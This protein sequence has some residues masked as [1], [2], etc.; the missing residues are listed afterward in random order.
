MRPISRAK[1]LLL[2]PRSEWRR[3]DAERRTPAQLL[4]SPL[5]WMAAIPAVAGF[6]GLSYVGLPVEGAAATTRLRLPLPAGLV[7]LALSYLLALGG[8]GLVGLIAHL[9][10]PSFGSRSDRHNAAKL[11]VYG[12]TAALAGGVF[13]AVPALAPL[14]VAVAVYSAYLLHAGLSTLMRTPSARTIPYAAVLV[15]AGAVAGLLMS[16]LRT[17][18]VARAAIATTR[19]AQAAAA[20]S[21]D[22]AADKIAKATEQL[23]AA[24]Q[25]AAARGAGEP[26]VLPGGDP[27]KGAV[28]AASLKAALPE[29]LGPLRRTTLEMRGGRVAD[30]VTSNARGDYVFQDQRLRVELTD[31]GTMAKVLSEAGAVIEGERETASAAERTWQD[32]GRTLHENYRKDGS[33]AQYTTT[34]R[35]GV[36][37]DLTGQRMTLDQVKAASSQ[38]DLNLLEALRRRTEP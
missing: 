12:S 5:W 28:P 29:T 11:A 6:I 25:T 16:S 19:D 13:L 17:T 38:I 3:I 36:V 22:A 34:L 32:K 4:R 1:H 30:Q 33:L 14:A 20:Q 8:V 2:N 26:G 31:L 15:L 24:G 23:E 35:N 21:L 37:V 27:D 9:T 10:A 7:W 18:L